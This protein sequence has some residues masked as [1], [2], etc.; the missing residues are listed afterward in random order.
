MRIPAEALE[1]RH[2]LRFA[3]EGEVRV[4]VGWWRTP[5]VARL[6]DVSRNGMRLQ[7]AHPMRRGAQYRFSVA[8]THARFK[9]MWVRRASDGNYEVGCRLRN[10]AAVSHAL[11]LPADGQQRRGAR[12]T[13]VSLPAWLRRPNGD[14]LP[15]R[16]VD[17]SYLGARL[18]TPETLSTFAGWTLELRPPGGDPVTVPARIV[19][20]DA[21]STRLAFEEVSPTAGDRLLALTV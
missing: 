7:V 14:A 21:R 13:A 10:A 9:A 2:E 1:K 5:V 18:K 20:S 3:H 15:V 8:N 11:Y 17:L 16:V 19:S 12:R 4:S 6:Q